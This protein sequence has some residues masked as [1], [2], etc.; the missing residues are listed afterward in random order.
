MIFMLPTNNAGKN[1]RDI[2]EIVADVQM[3]QSAMKIREWLCGISGL[4]PRLNE[5]PNKYYGSTI[6]GIAVI[7]YYGGPS[8][9]ATPYGSW[10]C[11]GGGC[12]NDDW[13]EKAEKELGLILLMQEKN[14]SSGCYGPV[15]GIT[16]DLEGNKLATPEWTA[17]GFWP[18]IRS[19]SPFSILSYK[20]LDEAIDTLNSLEKHPD[21]YESSVDEIL[22]KD[23]TDEQKIQVIGR[24]ISERYW[25]KKKAKLGFKDWVDERKEAG[26]WK[27]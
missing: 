27:D 17:L 23:Y 8:R 25:R 3:M 5:S 21:D 9:V 4:I 15:H 1:M 16:K 6:D 7:H 26:E 22:A 19:V 14:D 20:T 12:C 18:G 2:K 11:T 13:F 24:S 10:A